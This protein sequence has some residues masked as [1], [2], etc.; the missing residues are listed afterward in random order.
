MKSRRKR[1]KRPSPGGGAEIQGPLKN[2]YIAEKQFCS[3]RYEQK[4]ASFFLLS[5]N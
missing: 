5:V 3:M 1:P 4:R 2:N